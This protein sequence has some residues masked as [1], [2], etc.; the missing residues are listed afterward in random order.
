MLGALLGRKSS[1]VG[2]A[3]TAARGVGRASCERGDI[4]RAQESLEALQR[5]LDEM[6]AEFEEATLRVREA[7]DDTEPECAEV[8]IRPR[9]AD[10]A[11]ERVALV[12]TPWRVGPDG[13]AEPAY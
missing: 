3:T 5:R 7:S 4:G 1:S 10:L 2:R 12:W 6:E 13:I 8:L 11:V 9:K